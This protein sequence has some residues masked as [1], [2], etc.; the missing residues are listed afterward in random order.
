MTYP[1]PFY[2]LRLQGDTLRGERLNAGLLA[3]PRE[4]LP[5]VRFLAD[6]QRFVALNSSYAELDLGKWQAELPEVISR[7]P[8]EARASMMG[9]V[10][11]PFVVSEH[12]GTVLVENGQE[13]HELDALFDRLIAPPPRSV[14]RRHAERNRPSKLHGE[15]KAWLKA[16][17]VYSN[18]VEDLRRGRVVGQYPIDPASDLYCD[19]ALMNGALHVV[20]TLDLRGVE[21]LTPTMQ[22]QAAIKGITLDEA[23]ECVAG[24]RRIA[25]V[26]ASDYGAARPALHHIGRYA[27]Q[28]WDMSSSADKQAFSRFISEA[29]H[30]DI[31]QLALPQ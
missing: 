25:V 17:K 16:A 9:A 20:E 22:G 2:V 19:F 26:Q 12:P 6:P 23:K 29:L 21:R 18:R 7:F 1:L 11:R 24:G 31:P 14:I 4:G 8:V 15:I 30:A 10:M 3:L 13:A 5:I 28:V 27:D